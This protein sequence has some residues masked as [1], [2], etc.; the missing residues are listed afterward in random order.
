VIGD[1]G[2]VIVCVDE[3]NVYEFVGDEMGSDSGGV[4]SSWVLDSKSAFHVCP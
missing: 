3:E 4:G 1:D 2:D